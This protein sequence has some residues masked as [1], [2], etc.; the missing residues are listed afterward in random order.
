MANPLLASL[1]LLACVY[2]LLV[3]IIHIAFAAG[4]ARD[5][6]RLEL[7]AEGTLIVP[8]L[9]W[10]LATLAGGIF[11]VAVYWLIHHSALRRI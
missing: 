4:V 5:A 10:S 2:G 8:P 7:E 3:L 1:I 9:V 11:V 6:A